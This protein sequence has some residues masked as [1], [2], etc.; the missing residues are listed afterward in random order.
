MTLPD[1][2]LFWIANSTRRR[3]GS[4]L[5]RASAARCAVGRRAKT[6][7]GSAPAA[8]SG[9]PSTL[10]DSAQPADGDAVPIVQPM[11][12]AFGLVC[13]TDSWE[14][15]FVR[16]I[17]NTFSVFLIHLVGQFCVTGFPVPHHLR[18]TASL[19]VFLSARTCAGR[20]PLFSAT[21]HNG[22]TS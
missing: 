19:R 5:I 1:R 9:T 22:T 18:L 20:H 4:R 10:E 12:A 3:A 16:A 21:C 13:R 11:V 2:Q 6:T 14:R 8:M 15:G 17:H 7:N